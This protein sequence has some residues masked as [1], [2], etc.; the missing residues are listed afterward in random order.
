MSTPPVAPVKMRQVSAYTVFCKQ[1]YARLSIE[2]PGL[3]LVCASPQIS[4]LWKKLC[5]EEHK[6]YADLATNTPPR[7]VGKRKRRSEAQV[8]TGK[9]RSVRPA[10]HPCRPK[11]AFM[12][13]SMLQR[14]ELKQRTPKLKPADVLREIGKMW[15][16]LGPAERCVFQTDAQE[17]SRVYK[18]AMAQ[19]ALQQAA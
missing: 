3:T 18:T 12:L 5:P 2:T 4:A 16:L 14:A 11:T 7:P 8:P 6:V 13:F 1:T 19:Y 17:E 10:G 9:R 15:R